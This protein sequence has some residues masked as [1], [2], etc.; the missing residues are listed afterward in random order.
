MSTT[1]PYSL[2]IGNPE[3][4]RKFQFHILFK[5]VKMAPQTKAR[6]FTMSATT[7]KLDLAES[8]LK[9]LIQELGPSGFAIA[10]SNTNC[11]GKA[12]EIAGYGKALD[13]SNDVLLQRWH[14]AADEMHI[15]GKKLEKIQHGYCLPDVS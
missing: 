12:F 13:V 15:V 5:C 8:I 1:P 11:H 7:A 3:S 14:K 6:R 9:S 10:L 4:H 2:S